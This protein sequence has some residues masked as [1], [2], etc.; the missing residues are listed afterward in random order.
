MAQ[1]GNR[2]PRR[3]Q[4][5]TR[6]SQPPSNGRAAPDDAAGESAAERARERLAQQ[7]T[8]GQK[9]QTASQRARSAAPPAQRTRA[10]S[11]P[12]G[13]GRAGGAAS[14]R[15]PAKDAPKRSTAMTAAIFATA[16]VVLAVLVIV[17]V[18]VTGKTTPSKAGFGMKPAPAA[19]VNAISH[20]SA[21]AFATAGSTITSAGPSLISLS[22]LKSQP[23]LTSGGKPLIVYFGS[24]WCPYCAAS[25]WPL[26]IALARFGTFAKLRITASGTATGEPYPGTSTLSYYGSTYTS[27]Y[28][29]FLPTEQCSDLVSSSTSRAV[30]ECNGYEPLGTVSPKAQKI[31]LKYDYPPFESSTNEGGIPFIDFGN[32]FVEDG[33]FLDPSILAGLTHLQIAQSLGNPIASPAQPIHVSANFYTATICKLTGNKPG[34]VCDMPVVKQAATQLKL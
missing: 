30:E 16:L 8:S 11:P 22:T 5:P 15:A 20:V 18:S 9:R 29:S 12:A 1:S 6:G 17:L 32:H 7:R 2:P 26:S 13:R 4:S 21:S 25:R 33:D 31:L 23:P 28:V 10:G 14:R 34:S 19:V 24:N 3:G 27:P